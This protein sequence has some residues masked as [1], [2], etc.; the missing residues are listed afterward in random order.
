LGNLG[1]IAALIKINSLEHIDVR[2]S[3]SFA[4]LLE[5]IDILHHFELAT[6]RVDLCDTSWHQL[7]HQSNQEVMGGDI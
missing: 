4:S 2:Y 6:S 3:V 5:A 7:V 1:Q